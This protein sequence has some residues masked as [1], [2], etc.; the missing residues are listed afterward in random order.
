MPTTFIRLIY[1]HLSPYTWVLVM[2]DQIKIWSSNCK[3]WGSRAWTNNCL[4]LKSTRLIQIILQASVCASHRKH[5]V[6][7]YQHHINHTN[8]LC[9]HM[10]RSC[11][12]QA[13]NKIPQPLCFRQVTGN[14]P[15]T[16]VSAFL[17][18]NKKKNHKYVH[19]HAHKQTC[20]PHPHTNTGWFTLVS[21]NRTNLKEQCWFHT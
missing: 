5:T 2:R 14:S 4:N 21:C 17:Y 10:Q 12:V 3:I 7:P 19:T 11:S 20:S 1:I 13:H 15:H 16:S 18:R 6:F 8:T 9:G